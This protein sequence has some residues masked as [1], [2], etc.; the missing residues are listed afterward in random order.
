MLPQYQEQT[1]NGWMEKEL[2]QVNHVQ[3]RLNNLWKK[4]K[5]TTRISDIDQSLTEVG[6]WVI[7]KYDNKMFYLPS[8]W[9]NKHPNNSASILTRWPAIFFKTD[10]TSCIAVKCVERKQ[11]QSSIYYYLV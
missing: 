1:Y 5:Y 8:G 7:Y 10:N 2:C 11:F 6:K 4:S 3:D 9:E